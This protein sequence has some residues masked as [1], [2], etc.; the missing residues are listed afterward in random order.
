MPSTY[1]L[2][3]PDADPTE[4]FHFWQ[5]HPPS[6]I[7]LDVETISLKERHPLGF[8]LAVGPDEA[9]Y[10]DLTE[11][12]EEKL[13]AIIPWLKDCR[14]RKLAHNWMFDMG[15]FPLIP[16]VGKALDRSFLFDTN[17]AARLL[18]YE[19]TSLPMLV[20]LLFNSIH[21]SAKEIL[22]T[23]NTKTMAGIPRDEVAAHC[24]ADVK[25]C[26][27]LYMLWRGKIEA[28]YPEY[29]NVEM[30]VIPILIDMSMRGISIDQ[31]K[32]AEL[33][34][35]YS[36][37]IEFYRQQLQTQG[38]EDPGSRVQIGMILA[39]RGNFLPLTRGRQWLRTDE[40]SLEFLD[41]SLASAVLQYRHFSKF[42]STYL[43]PLEG[44]DRFYTEYYLD[45]VVGRLNSRNRNIQNIPLDARSMMLPDSGVFTTG[46]YCLHPDTRVLTADLRW[47]T[48]ADINEGDVLI[49]IDEYHS[50]RGQRRKLR[51]SNILQKSS[52][53]RPSKRITMA[54]GRTVIASNEHPWLVLTNGKYMHP[55]WTR[56]DALQLG[57]RIRQL[58]PV[59]KEDT[60]YYAG[61]L[62]GFLDG[63]GWI[64]TNYHMVGFA[65][66]DN[67]C[68]DYAC[69]LLTEMGYHI[70]E[71][72]GSSSTTHQIRLTLQSEM[73][74]LIGS[75]RP[76][77]LLEKSEYL[78]QDYEPPKK[79]AWLEVTAIEDVGEQDLIS[80][81][82]T[83]HTYIAE[84]LFTHNSQEH[85]YILAH[86][87]Q[88]RD[89]LEVMAQEDKKKRDIHQFTADK[90]GVARKLAKVLNYAIIYGA[91]PRTVMEQA[92]IK[93]LRRCQRLIEDWFHVYKGAADWIKAA[94]EE[95]LR[96][97]W[98]L[99]TL[100][101]R[102]I[103]LPLE[104]EDGQRRKAVNYPILGSDGEVIKRAIILCNK[105]GL[106]PPTM[107]ITV[108]DSISWDGDVKE[109]LPVEELE[110]I[111][112]FRVPFEIKTS[113]RWE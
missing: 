9:F 108:H 77:R 71:S 66:N 113:F 62:A 94:Q 6:A 36:A 34:E 101:G 93:D 58:G 98:A 86:V 16:I 59:W 51:P 97:G 81:E 23:H 42:K 82:T 7:A 17:I 47:T 96:T 111:P 38:I 13:R 75:V 4:R 84:G 90:M 11:P 64:D 78:W 10:F 73:L 1:Y 32:R 69:F 56:T 54:D 80:I 99:P 53:R 3:F 15:V 91:T 88:D 41:D 12:D 110:Y 107:A 105:R 57:S 37:E 55:E 39:H 25:M 95:G 100:F 60:G 89:M 102:K 76:K 63:E 30:Q 65:Q 14:V 45:T 43:D 19:E 87:S 21:P 33:V 112:K 67:I 70:K 104:S 2:G 26:Y 18:G 40:S 52:V 103:K 46:D 20:S 83:T 35:K 72:F 92:K 106:G 61:W 68:L 49:G 27:R 29:F 74:R 44:E 5:E 50:G 22:A 79:D 48:L 85:L 8:G 109:Q 31:H 28:Q 24:L